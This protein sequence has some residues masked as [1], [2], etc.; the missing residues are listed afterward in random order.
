MAT[1]K[2]KSQIAAKARKPS[3]WASAGVA[4]A[5]M[6]TILPQYA[7]AFALGGALL[8]LVGTFMPAKAH[9]VEAP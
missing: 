7:P 8:G 2:R 1:K 3:T 9:E 6:A 5:G 4:V